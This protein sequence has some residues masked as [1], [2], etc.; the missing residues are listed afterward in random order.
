MEITERCFVI[1][2][3]APRRPVGFRA[4][5]HKSESAKEMLLSQNMFGPLPPS[6][7]TSSPDVSRISK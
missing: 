5:V 3:P 4:G 1:E 6:P 2:M 7:P